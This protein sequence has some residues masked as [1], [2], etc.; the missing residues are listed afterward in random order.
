MSRHTQRLSLVE[1]IESGGR[2]RSHKA[3]MR[4]LYEHGAQTD[5]CLSRLSGVSRSGV[6]GRISEL[7]EIGYIEERNPVRCATTG[8]LVRTNRLTKKG[9]F[10]TND[11]IKKEAAL[12]AAPP[13]FVFSHLTDADEESFENYGEK[14]AIPTPAKFIAENAAGSFKP[15]SFDEVA[16]EACTMMTATRKPD[17]PVSVKVAADAPAGLMTRFLKSRFI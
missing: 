6:C 3:I 5:L 13:V 7:T 1:L 15:V 12:N 17:H 10:A 8:K 4:V 16:D 14:L 11:F 2:A 9:Y